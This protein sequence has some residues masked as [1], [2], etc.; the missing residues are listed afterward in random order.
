MEADALQFIR[1]CPDEL[2]LK[3][4]QIHKLIYAIFLRMKYGYARAT[5]SSQWRAY[6]LNWCAAADPGGRVFFGAPYE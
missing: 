2:R 5:A 1:I 3:K 6:I 4:S